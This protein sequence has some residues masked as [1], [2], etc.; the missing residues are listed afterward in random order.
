MSYFGDIGENSVGICELK[1]VDENDGVVIARTE[2]A[3]STAW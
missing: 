3:V 1:Q 2:A